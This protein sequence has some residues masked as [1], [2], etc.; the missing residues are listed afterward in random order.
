MEN[1]PVNPQNNYG[2]Y[3]PVNGQP[4]RLV[5][6]PPNFQPVQKPSHSNTM[7]IIVLTVMGVL[8]TGALIVFF[9]FFKA[10]TT[11][12]YPYKTV[13]GMNAYTAT[14]KLFKVPLS[15]YSCAPEDALHQSNK[16]EW[17]TQWVDCIDASWK[18][19]AVDSDLALIQ[20]KFYEINFV[21]ASDTSISE[22]CRDELMGKDMVD[23]S[24]SLYIDNDAVANSE[25]A[26][27]TYNILRIT[28]ANHIKSNKYKND[29]LQQGLSF[30]TDKV[31]KTEDRVDEYNRFGRR[32]TLYQ[33]CLAL[34]SMQ[35]AGKLDKTRDSALLNA[36]THPALGKNYTQRYT[37]KIYGSVATREKMV[38][39]A[40][41]APTTQTCNTWEWSNPE[42]D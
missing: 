25:A 28:L 13:E 9:V 32:E 10:L 20:G 22:F 27:D 23:C 8:L 42:V 35:K 34:V 17:F 3:N 41:E 2:Q 7:L 39:R 24:G 38:Q 18:T 21:T 6:P 11:S 19:D 40:T 31:K 33:D 15:N 36:I 14:N 29:G 37:D 1:Q 26:K 30:I 16:K 5:P 12:K 4:P